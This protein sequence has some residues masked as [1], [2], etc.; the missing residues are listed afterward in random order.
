M[1]LAVQLA[2]LFLGVTAD[3]IADLDVLALHLKSHRVS[4]WPGL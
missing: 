4:S 1:Q 2:Q 3:R